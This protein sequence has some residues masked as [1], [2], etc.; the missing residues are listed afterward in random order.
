MAELLA[1]ADRGDRSRGQRPDPAERAQGLGPEDAVDRE[2]GVALELA[3][4]RRGLVA[5]DAVLAAGVEAERVEPVLELGDVVAA[6]VRAALVEQA[7]AEREAA[8]DER[9][10]GLGSADPVDAD[11]PGLLERADG[12]PRSRGRSAPASSSTGT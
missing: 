7:V 1:L 3:Q 11:A 2:P 5:E 9:G 10:P 6:E 8:L 12:A 4:R